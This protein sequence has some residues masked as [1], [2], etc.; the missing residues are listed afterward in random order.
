MPAGN[1]VTSY[2]GQLLI[3]EQRGIGAALAHEVAVEPLPGDAFQLA[4]EVELG[5]FA[6]VAP[7]GVEQALGDVKKQR[8]R[9]HVSQVFQ[10]EIDGF[11]DD[12]GV[13][14]DGRAHQIGG[15]LQ[16]GVVVEL[17]GQ[18][19][20]GQFDAVAFD[21]READF[22]RIAIG[23]HSLDLDGLARRLW[24]RNHRLGGEI[25]GDPQRV[26]IFHIEETVFI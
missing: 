18:P 2:V 24:R 15:Q 13:L 3:H 12:P 7:F 17:G 5:R 21:A 4:E 8:G 22:E 16:D 20:F 25:E 23:P 1:A 26:G 11:A 19:F 10:T 9:P 14:G 6:G